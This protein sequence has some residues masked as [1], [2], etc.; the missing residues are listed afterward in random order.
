MLLY[1]KRGDCVEILIQILIILELLLAVFYTITICSKRKRKLSFIILV[2]SIMTILLLLFHFFVFKTLPW[3]GKGNGLF[4]LVAI[5]FSFPMKYFYR[6][7]MNYLLTLSSTSSVYVVFAFMTAVRFSH[8][9]SDD[10]F[11]LAI[12]IVQTIFF[13]L[14]WETFSSFMRNKYVVVLRSVNKKS[15]NVLLNFSI[16][17]FIFLV[18]INYVFIKDG[19]NILKLLIVL[20]LLLIVVICYGLFSSLVTANR[21]VEYFKRE[22]RFDSLTKIRNRKCLYEDAQ[23]YMDRKIEFSLIFM[24]LDNF[25]EINDYYGHIVGDCYLLNFANEVTRVTKGNEFYRISGDEF[26]LLSLKEKRLDLLD[27][28]NHLHIPNCNSDIEFLGVSYGVADYPFD[29]NNLGKL[30]SCADNRMYE[31][32]RYRKTN[33]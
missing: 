5:V 14:S 6:Q 4:L 27:I 2:Y 13:L 10:Y 29:G 8:L 7:D 1:L 11:Y 28:L 31:E 17:L 9:L 32:K 3:Y 24:D 18:L 19:N 16:L 26:V 30:L 15:I 22:S 23:K 25:K 21:H 33:L 20:L 12:F